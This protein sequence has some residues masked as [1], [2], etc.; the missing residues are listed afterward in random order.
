MAMIITAADRN[1]LIRLASILPLGNPERREILASII[2]A[3]TWDGDQPYNKPFAIDNTSCY[4]KDKGDGDVGGKGTPGQGTCYRLH[5]EYGS[6]NSGK[7]GSS[8]RKKYNK[9]YRE[10]YLNNDSHKNRKICPDGAG[11]KGPC[12]KS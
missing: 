5:N 12:G 4:K 7:P 2:T 6:A 8:A 10:K 3:R 9:K 1:A 11:G